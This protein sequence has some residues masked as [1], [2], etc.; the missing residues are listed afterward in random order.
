LLDGIAD[1]TNKS[2][3]VLANY[4]A[5]YFDDVWAHFRGLRFV[6]AP[7][8]ELHYI[9]G[10]SSFYGVL[11]PVEEIYA[12]MLQ[13]LGFAAIACRPLRKRNSK[14]ELIEFDVTARWPG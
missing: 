7:G 4:V 13:R 1:Q 8:A 5:R 11:V 12:E 2:G 9:V 6:L 14:K 3:R 10:N